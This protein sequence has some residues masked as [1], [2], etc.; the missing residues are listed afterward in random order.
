MNKSIFHKRVAALRQRMAGSSRTDCDTAWIIQPEN[1]RY[2]SGFRAGDPQ[3]TESSGSLPSNE[4][5]CVFVTDSR[6]TSE[7]QNEVVG[8]EV[9]TQKQGVIEA[10]PEFLKNMETR[11]LGFEEG[12]L[13]WGLHRQLSERFDRISPPV[14]L[15]PLNGVV[16]KMREVKNDLEIKALEA[17][18]DLMSAI[19]DEIISGLKPGMTEKEVAWQIEGLA[20][21]S[22]AECLAFPSIVASGPNSALPHAVPTDRKLGKCEPVILDVGVRLDGY[23]SDMTRTVFLEEPGEDLRKIYKT[24][25]QAQI[26]ALK[27]I[28]PGAVCQ[29]VT[30]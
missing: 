17:S 6:Y 11:N 30:R 20:R 14:R 22:G 1:R 5:R 3:L 21:E 7:A 16:E 27:E 2:L 9:Q 28:L 13:T 23:C 8:F 26:A 19:L 29:R 15:T 24:V 18:A 12:Y 10:L 4:T 25:R